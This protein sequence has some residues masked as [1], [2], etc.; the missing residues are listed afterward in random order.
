[1]KTI[2]PYVKIERVKLSGYWVV[3]C[4]ICG[5]VGEIYGVCPCKN[6]WFRQ[7]DTQSINYQRDTKIAASIMDVNGG[8]T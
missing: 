2:G 4:R 3:I 1:M 8:A 5:K 6:S 7:Y